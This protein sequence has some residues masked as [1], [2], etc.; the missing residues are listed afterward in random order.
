MKKKIIVCVIALA[1]IAALLFVIP[2][3]GTKS[4]SPN[5]PK[6]DVTTAPAPE[7]NATE[8]DKFVEEA[9]KNAISHAKL[10]PDYA[11][12]QEE[13]AKIVAKA[14]AK[15]MHPTD[16]ELKIMFNTPVEFYGQVLDQFDNPVIGANITCEWAHP[17]SWGY[18]GPG[19]APRKLQSNAPDGRFEISN[20]KA[21]RMSVAVF[22]PKGYDEQVRDTK[23]IQIAQTPARLLKKLDLENATPEQL[24]NLSPFWGRPEAYKG[25]KAKPVIFRLKKL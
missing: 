24:E 7:N 11:P 12:T 14:R 15:E 9:I 19:Y 16:E 8:E 2:H 3:E 6:F 20:L 10:P 22:P 25:D 4:A 5:P 23:E 1:T 13:R 18:M 17:G 21:M